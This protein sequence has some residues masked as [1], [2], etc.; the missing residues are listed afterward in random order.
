MSDQVQMVLPEKS[1]MAAM[2]SSESPEWYTPEDVIEDARY[3]LGGIDLDP[4]SCERAQE[5]IRAARW[6]GQSENAL[7]KN[8]KW[9]NV[10]GTLRGLRAFVNPPSA[11]GLPP[12]HEWWERLGREVDAGVVG[13]FVWVAFNVMQLESCAA[14][15][16]KLGLLRP[17]D[18]YV[19]MPYDRTPFERPTKQIGFDGKV[20][21]ETPKNPPNW[22]WFLCYSWDRGV[23]IRF[24][25]TFGQRGDVLTG[26]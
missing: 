3:V 2:H 10:E 26:F 18:C 13:S 15:A 21:L 14:T 22:A 20:V 7:D 4:A 8:T 12:V 9:G 23:K 17:A 16:A 1:I 11:K 24:K 19:C 25:K 6:I 5:R